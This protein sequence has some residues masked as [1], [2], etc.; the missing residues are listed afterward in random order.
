[1]SVS[2]TCGGKEKAFCININIVKGVNKRDALNCRC[3]VTFDG[4]I[5][6]SITSSADSTCCQVTSGVI[7]R[8]A[9]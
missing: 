5:V 9:G 3:G 1:M 2:W 7:R 6:L 4:V 8:D